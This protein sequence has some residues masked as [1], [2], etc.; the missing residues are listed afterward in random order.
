M[1]EFRRSVFAEV[2]ADWPEDDRREFARLLT[3]F[4]RNY[5]ALG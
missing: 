2:M 5:G 3:A 1:H 4:V